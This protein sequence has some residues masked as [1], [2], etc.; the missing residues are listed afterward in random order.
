MYSR[1]IR[2]CS[3]GSVVPKWWPSS[4]GS[5]PDLKGVAAPVGEDQLPEATSAGRRVGRGG[6]ETA[7]PFDDPRF[8]AALNRR[9]PDDPM[10]RLLA[11]LGADANVVHLSYRKPP[12]SGHP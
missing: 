1:I 5:A 4:A 11:T 7:L 8:P 3:Q 2:N 9:P 6:G 12:L 10:P